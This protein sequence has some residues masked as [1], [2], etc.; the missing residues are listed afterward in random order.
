MLRKRRSTRLLVCTIPPRPT[1][2]VPRGKRAPL[3]KSPL[4][5]LLLLPI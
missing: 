1:Y 4:M 3:V 2:R 5:L